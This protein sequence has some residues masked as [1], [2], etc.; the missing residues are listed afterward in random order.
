MKYI[1]LIKLTES[2]YNSLLFISNGRTM[3]NIYEL[4]EE[5]LKTFLPPIDIADYITT[6][7]LVQFVK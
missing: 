5:P 7:N 4:I 2:E 3:F 1:N 6:T